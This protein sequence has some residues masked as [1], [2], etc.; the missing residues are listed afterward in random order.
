MAHFHFLIDSYRKHIF[1][2]N[3][4]RF[5]FNLVFG[6]GECESLRNIFATFIGTI[7]TIRELSR[8]VSFKRGGERV[9]IKCDLF[10]VF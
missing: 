4:S 6:M 10:V 2:D 3:S 9:F 7:V 1:A 8:S 5:V